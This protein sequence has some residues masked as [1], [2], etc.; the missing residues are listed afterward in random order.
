M[1]EIVHDILAFLGFANWYRRFI[2]SYTSITAVLT[3][4]LRKPKE[5]PVQTIKDKGSIITPEARAA[6]NLLKEKF[7]EMVSLNHFAEGLPTRLETD[8]LGGGLYR[9]LT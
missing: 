6:I 1:L 4:L 8:A 7:A 5:G 9:V 2:C 3:D